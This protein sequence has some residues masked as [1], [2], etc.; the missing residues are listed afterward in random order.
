MR[1]VSYSQVNFNWVEFCP[2]CG[3]FFDTRNGEYLDISY[4]SMPA[5]FAIQVMVFRQG[6]LKRHPPTQ[7]NH[8]RNKKKKKKGFG[9]ES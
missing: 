5:E 4:E 9:E 7:T 8:Q 6:V 1:C 3:Y 2:C